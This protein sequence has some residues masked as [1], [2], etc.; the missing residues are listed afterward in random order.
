MASVGEKT[1][2][3]TYAS[4]GSYKASVCGPWTRA[5]WSFQCVATGRAEGEEYSATCVCVRV[6][7]WANV[8]V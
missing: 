7:A 2:S 8:C 5:V 1:G 3:E 6:H 4:Q